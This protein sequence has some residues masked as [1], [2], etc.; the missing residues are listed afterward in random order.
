M[1]LFSAV[2]ELIDRDAR[3]LSTGVRMGNAEMPVIVIHLQRE[4]VEL[5][6]AVID[7]HLS[8]V[9]QEACDV[10]GVAIHA[11]IA[12]GLS[13]TDAER[14]MREKFARRFDKRKGGGA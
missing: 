2:Q 12:A 5:S 4:A 8:S 9:Q 10:L 7:R 1:S 14:I 11:C 6:Q 3:H 13:E